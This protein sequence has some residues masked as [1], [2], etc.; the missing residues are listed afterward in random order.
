MYPRLGADGGVAD[1]GPGFSRRVLIIGLAVVP[2]LPFRRSP[3]GRGDGAFGR[4]FSEA[5]G[6][7]CGAGSAVLW[8]GLPGVSPAA[9]A[10]PLPV[11]YRRCVPASRR[12]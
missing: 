12:R 8:R 2:I 3:D 7:D 5:P 9:L 6:A 11:G 4:A 1:P 10:L